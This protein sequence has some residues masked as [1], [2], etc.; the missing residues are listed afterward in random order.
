MNAVGAGQGTAIRTCA[1]LALALATFGT[2]GCAKTVEMLNSRPAA[3]GIAYV[4]IDKV[5]QAHPLHPELQALDD[6]ITLLDTQSVSA[7]QAVTPAQ[8]DAQ[9]ALERDLA[10][11][12]AQFEQDMLRKREY[13]QAQEQAA[14][15]NIAAGG[16]SP[17][18]GDVLEVMRTEFNQQMSQLQQSGAKTLEAYRASLFKEDQAHL[19]SVQELLAADVQAK[20]RAK[21]TQLVSNETTYQVQL[22]HQ[23]QD[24]RLN[25]KTKLENLTLSAQDRSQYA[26][27]LQDIE[28]REEFLTNQLK[29][30]DNATLADYQ[31]TLQSQAA[32]KFDAERVATEKQTSA[33][34]AARQDDMNVQFRQQAAA[35]STKFNQRLND[36]NTAITTNPALHQKAQE[37][38]NQTQAKFEADA[39]TAMAS[40]RD[41]RKA[42][43]DKYSAIAHMQFQDDQAIQAQIDG[44][45]AQ[46]RDLYAKILDQVQQ[47]VGDV[48]QSRG[49]A[50]VFDSV[51]GSGGAV[52]LTDQVAKAV[53]ALPSATPSPAPSGG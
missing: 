30:K 20:M 28:T 48:A 24:Q 32:A 25:L 38:Q 35:L 2:A 21:E 6:Q 27:Q 43:V 44:I 5:V 16:A 3:H 49:I 12:E 9:A 29:S 7:P 45:A 4:D 46:R 11:A 47:Q 26:A 34:L 19:R 23:D 14:M 8:R 1:A 31:K 15:A 41:T 18:G 53:A 13:Y 42:L 36:V 50:I 40:Y 10:A 52:D 39:A 17:Q 37:I 51:A 33:K 22:A